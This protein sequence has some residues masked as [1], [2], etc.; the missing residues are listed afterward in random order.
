MT[1]VEVFMKPKTANVV[2]MPGIHDSEVWSVVFSINPDNHEPDPM[3][4]INLIREG[5][6]GSSISKFADVLQV[7]KTE[8][9]NLLHLNPRTA[10]R[11]ASKK[12][13][14]G[15]SDHLVQIT[16][17]YQRC[18]EV[19]ADFEKAMRW[20]RSPNYSLGDQ[21]PWALL[22]TS[23]GID[24]VQDTLTRIEHGVFV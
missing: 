8:V 22:D 10:Q 20:L 14:V 9:Y 2:K 15:K 1:H 11:A 17:V 23:E 13:D 16:K 21:T 7:P 12:L 3:R 24:L 18:V 5:V 19:F 6:P 4:L